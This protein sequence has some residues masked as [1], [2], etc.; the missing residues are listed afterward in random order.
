MAKGRKPRYHALYISAECSRLI[1]CAGKE[2]HG[3]KA[4]LDR[5]EAR[6]SGWVEEEES[7]P[8]VINVY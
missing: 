1:L 7:G 5:R 4:T 2:P 3:E 8:E 6:R